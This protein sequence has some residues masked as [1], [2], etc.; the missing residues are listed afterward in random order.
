MPKFT[1][2]GKLEETEKILCKSLEK[3]TF[4]FSFLYQ[5]SNHVQLIALAAK[6]VDYTNAPQ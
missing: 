4:P 5:V 1:L 2:C 6:M 3:Q